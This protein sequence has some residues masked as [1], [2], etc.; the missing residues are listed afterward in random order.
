MGQRFVHH[1]RCWLWQLPGLFIVHTVLFPDQVIRKV[2]HSVYDMLPAACDG[3]VLLHCLVRKSRD[4]MY[5][6]HAV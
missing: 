4:A 2:S 3:S 6:A 1:L 5:V